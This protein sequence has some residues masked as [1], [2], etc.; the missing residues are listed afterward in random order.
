MLLPVKVGRWRTDSFSMSSQPDPTTTADVPTKRTNRRLGV[1]RFR[2]QVSAIDE[3]IYDYDPL[4]TG[5]SPDDVDDAYEGLSVE[6]MRVLRD[7]EIME[8]D[9]A[10]AV[11]TV[12]P[13][14]SREL[15]TRIV[16]AWDEA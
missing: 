11:R 4:G 9:A 16:E 3:L 12:V 10:L 13:K 6:L 14:A 7:A 1:L 5:S 15:V 2:Q 8:T